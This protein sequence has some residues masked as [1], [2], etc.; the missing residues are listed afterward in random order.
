MIQ[1]LT[2]GGTTHAV[3]QTSYD[4]AGRTE[5]IAQRMN[6]ATF[7][8]LPASACTAGTASSAGPDRIVKNSY[9]AAG[10]VTKVQTAYGVVGVQAD[11]AT[12]TYTANGEVDYVIDAENNRTDYSYDGFDRLVKTEYPSATKGANTANASDYEQLALLTRTAM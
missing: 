2:A 9:D 4:G 6:S 5:C 1:K 10:Q 12:T 3:S 11:E 7:G 8:S